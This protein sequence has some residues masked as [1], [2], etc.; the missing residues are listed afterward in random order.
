MVPMS[1]LMMARS[2]CVRRLASVGV[3][4]AVALLCMATAAQAAVT[5]ASPTALTL[6]EGQPGQAYPG[7]TFTFNGCPAGTTVSWF[8]S[9]LGPLSISSGGTLSG[10]LSSNQPVVNATVSISVA[11]TG[12]GGATC[13]DGQSD[14]NFYVLPVVYTFAASRLGGANALPSAVDVNVGAAE[15]YIAESGS[16]QVWKIGQA[17]TNPPNTA[18]QNPALVTMPGLNWPNGLA[19]L[20]TANDVVAT[21]FFGGSAA[22]SRDNVASAFTLTDCQNAAGVDTTNGF[23]G[24]IRPAFVACAGSNQVFQLSPNTGTVAG[25]LALATGPNG[26]PAPAG[27]AHNPVNNMP[28]P[29]ADNTMLVGDARNDTLTLLAPGSSGPTQLDV[30]TLEPGCVPANIAVADSGASPERV[31]V[32]CPGTG[33]INQVTVD[34]KGPDFLSSPT[35]IPTGNTATSRP[36]GIAFDGQQNDVV[37]TNSG[38]DNVLVFDV[39]TPTTQVVLPVGDTPSGVAL[40]PNVGGSGIALAYVASLRDG[41][42]WVVDPPRKKKWLKVE[43]KRKRRAK[44]RPCAPTTLGET[45]VSGNVDTGD[46]SGT[47]TEE[48]ETGTETE[49]DTS[50]TD[51]GGDSSGSETEGDTSE[52]ETQ[53]G[54]SGSGPQATESRKKHKKKKKNKKDDSDGSET[55]DAS[56]APSRKQPSSRSKEDRGMSVEENI[57]LLRSRA[58]THP[59]IPP[60][61]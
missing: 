26:T 54:T 27:V 3:A 12:G 44:S 47:G 20:S 45:P 50:G 61:D 58:H 46:T 8:G 19:A 4:A 55:Q 30:Q 16:N 25:S 39:S 11:V 21:N 14:T 59:L 48:D 32:A 18:N 43:K 35:V 5:I 57:A 42:V 34:N 15:A 24:F 49:G 22:L 10:T 36:F 23:F 31:F 53:S 60:L 2:A 28:D 41:T 7:P 1:L 38:D 37:L 51:T 52:S 33:T 40:F 29:N 6:P 9:G 13:P 17:T 56:C